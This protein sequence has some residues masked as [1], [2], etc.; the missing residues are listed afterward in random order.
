LPDGLYPSLIRLSTVLLA[1]FS[2][3]VAWDE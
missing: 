2:Q 1:S 3:I